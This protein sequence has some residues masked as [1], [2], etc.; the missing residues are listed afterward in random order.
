MVLE[1]TA[2]R[3]AGSGAALLSCFTSLRAELLSAAGTETL[4]SSRV[5]F[6]LDRK[7]VV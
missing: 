7:S 2:S 3:V 1:S 5:P 4:P 6:R